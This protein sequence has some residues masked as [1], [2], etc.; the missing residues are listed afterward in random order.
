MHKME[1]SYIQTEIFITLFSILQ[2]S[3]FLIIRT[4]VQNHI[5]IRGVVTNYF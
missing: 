4:K 5:S 2:I 3:P 1:Y